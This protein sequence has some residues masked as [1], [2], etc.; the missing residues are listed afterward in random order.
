M[1]ASCDLCCIDV[2]LVEVKETLMFCL[3]V[4]FTGLVI[5]C[6]ALFVYLFCFVCNL[7]VL[8]CV[9]V[10]MCGCVPVPVSLCVCISVLISEQ[11]KNPQIFPYRD[12]HMPRQTKISRSPPDPTSGNFKRSELKQKHF[13]KRLISTLK[14]TRAEHKP[15][16][17]V[18]SKRLNHFANIL[19]RQS[20]H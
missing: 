18:L 11:T 10:C 2:A 5:V 15:G 6:K 14:P 3:F 19:T 7:F 16:N 4:C 13:I 8:L 12:E 17:A 20:R 1:V 9:F